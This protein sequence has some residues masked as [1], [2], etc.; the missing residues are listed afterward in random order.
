MNEVPKSG[1]TAARR[2]FSRSRADA[3]PGA[4][5]RARSTYA[6]ANPGLALPE[7]RLREA[8]QQRGVI[9]VAR[10][11]GAPEAFGSIQISRPGDT[12]RSPGQGVHPAG[13]PDQR[14]VIQRHGVRGVAGP[15][16]DLGLRHHEVRVGGIELARARETLQRAVEVVVPTVEERQAP[17]GALVERIGSERLLVQ[18]ARPREIA[19]RR[20]RNRRAESALPLEWRRR[21]RRGWKR[22]PVSP[23]RAPQIT[24]GKVHV[25]LSRSCDTGTSHPGHRYVARGVRWSRSTRPLPSTATPNRK[26]SVVSVWKPRLAEMRVRTRCDEGSVTFKSPQGIR[27]ST[28]RALGS[29]YQSDSAEPALVP[30]YRSRAAVPPVRG[31]SFAHPG[32][33]ASGWTSPTS[34]PRRRFGPDSDTR[35]PY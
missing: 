11:R 17:E 16:Q 18:R 21:G 4:T 1:R 12:L 10:Q 31:E 26:P 8:H 35:A 34:N 9:G 5:A 33:C 3:S 27:T 2:I 29:T 25:A 20:T 23:P 13:I 32:Q 15:R 24:D 28:R 22:R 6:R 14:G 30:G 7:E 19:R